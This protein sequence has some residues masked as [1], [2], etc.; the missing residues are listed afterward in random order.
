MARLSA[1]LAF[2][3]FCFPSLG[4]AAAT[5]IPGAVSL[6]P[7]TG[8]Y[9]V[10]TIEL[11]LTDYDRENPF[12]PNG[13]PRSFMISLFYPAKNVDKYPLAPYMGPGTADFNEKSFGLPA[14]TLSLIAPTSHL[15]APFNLHTTS[16]L[17][18][19][20]TGFGTSRQ[21]YTTFAEDLAS[22][23]Y[24]VA[25]IDHPYDAGV[26]EFPDGTLI[27]SDPATDLSDPATMSKMMDARVADAL[28]TFNRLLHGN[29][30]KSIPGVRTRLRVHNAGMFGHS[31]GGAATAAAMVADNRIR[32]GINMDGQLV[33]PAI[34]YG[35][36]APFLLMGTPVHNLTTDATWG[37][38]WASLTG[39]RRA[40]VLTGALH[41]TFSDFPVLAQLLGAVESGAFTKEALEA[42]FGTIEGA[43]ANVVQRKYVREFFGYVLRG[44]SGKLFDGPDS[45]F[46]EVVF[47][48]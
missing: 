7:G 48:T 27:L 33:G 13:G 46:P 4:G 3:V 9:D 47:Q 25:T 2:T 45:A 24:L 42:L 29:L 43:R 32:G 20:S 28:H 14:G 17:I 41:L 37:T 18:I 16:K 36:P 6:P 23:G 40:L 30:T 22:H 15:G 11:Q 35:L 5:P 19:F 38:F 12:V 39:W 1:F 44:E 21:G 10:G 34:S 31:L 8:P 26:V